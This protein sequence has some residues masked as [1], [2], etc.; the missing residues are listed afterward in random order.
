M[1][2]HLNLFLLPLS[3]HLRR[4]NL[5]V[6]ISLCS[7]LNRLSLP[8]HG[9]NLTL[10]L[11]L[12]N[13]NFGLVGSLHLS[14][15]C[16]QVREILMSTHVHQLFGIG[17]AYEKPE[18]VE[19]QLELSEKLLFDFFGAFEELLHGHGRSENAWLAFDDALY[20]LVDVVRQKLG[21]F[22]EALLVFQSGSYRE[23]SREDE[24]KLLGAHG[25]DFERVFHRRLVEDAAR[26]AWKNP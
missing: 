12:S 21:V 20:E 1:C 18:L 25:L 2:L 7:V 23:D 16:P 15:L 24:G 26:L 11:G 17:V 13:L 19:L 10:H 5:R 6:G 22:F 14:L 9:P 3:F 4:Y 8:E